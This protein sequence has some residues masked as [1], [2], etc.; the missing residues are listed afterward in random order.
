LLAT[1]EGI[2]Y[3]DDGFKSDLK[4]YGIQ[5]PVSVMGINVFQKIDSGKYLV[6]SFSGI[7][8]WEPVTGKI[9]DAITRTEFV[10]NGQA[11]PPF[12][13]VTVAGFVECCDTSMVIFD[14]G[15]G[16]MALR[17]KNPFPAVP[18]NIIQASPLSLWN[19]SLEIHTG[20]IFE[21]VLG[22]FYILVVPLVGLATMFILV[23]GFF[24]WWLPMR[25]RST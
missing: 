19:T 23:S 16:V 13:N 18:G 14:Y 6:G 24:A 7:F 9:L 20:R 1:S 2:Y 11:G 21:P 22:P 3:S 25:G 5:P 12:G 4:I 8:E 17:G 15:H 10:G